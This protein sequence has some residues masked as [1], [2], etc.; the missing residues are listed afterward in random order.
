MRGIFISLE[1]IDGAGKS[2]HLDQL[3]AALGAGGRTVLRT[4]EPGGTAL[5]EQLR[6][7]VLN[8]PMDAMTEALL[9]FAARRDHIVG[10]IRPALERGEIVV[11]DRFSDAT[12]AYQGGGRGLDWR[13]LEQLESWV[14]ARTGGRPGEAP[15]Q[16]DLTLWFDLPPAVAAQRLSGVRLPDRFES[17]PLQFFEQ[18][19]QAYARRCEAHERR[20][21]RIAADQT[22]QQV[23]SAVEQELQRRN[24]IS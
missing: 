17:Q 5:A 20:F 18:V 2:S 19:T 11:C 3:C 7:L 23:W 10:V 9:V 14:Q 22:P 13:L 15:L 16:P 24:L 12:F 6:T 8:Q 1:G 4:R 21:A